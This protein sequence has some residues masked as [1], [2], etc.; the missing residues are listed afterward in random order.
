MSHFTS[1]GHVSKGETDDQLKPNIDV[2]G[3]AELVNAVVCSGD[4]DFMFGFIFIATA[5]AAAAALNI[6]C[7]IQ[8]STFLMI[9]DLV[10]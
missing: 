6:I 3:N 2:A 4:T 5:A 10:Q 1:I 8:V 9:T 7:E